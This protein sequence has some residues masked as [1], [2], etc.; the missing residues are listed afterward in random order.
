MPFPT[1]RRTLKGAAL[2]SLAVALFAAAAF[3]S[4][5]AG[6]AANPPYPRPLADVPIPT[7]NGKPI[8]VKQY[9]GKVVLMAVISESCTPCVNSIAMLNRAQKDLGAQGL[10]V[11]AAVGDPNGQ[12]SLQAFQ[13]RYRPN[14][15]I[16]YLI[17]SQ[18]LKLGGYDANQPHVNVPVF[19]FIDRKG[20]VQFQVSGESPFFKDE[21]GQLRNTLQALLNKQ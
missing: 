17:P 15:P 11:V 9:R 2:A 6:L 14:F 20:V 16:G 12:Y 3:V 19:I 4:T 7:P 1:L 13:A 10:Q 18:I 21:E 5:P 8:D